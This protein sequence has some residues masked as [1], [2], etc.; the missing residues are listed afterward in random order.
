MANGVAMRVSDLAVGPLLG[1]LAVAQRV[2][3]AD[4][5]LG[6]ARGRCL[7]PHLRDARTGEALLEARKPGCWVRAIRGESAGELRLE[8][9]VRGGQGLGSH[10][11]FG[12]SPLIVCPNSGN[13]ILTS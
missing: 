11:R 5:A 9:G 13:L 7:V 3:R 2:E 8:V 10:F 4:E 12:A 1:A 6:V